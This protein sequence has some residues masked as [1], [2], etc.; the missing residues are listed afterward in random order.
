[1]TNLIRDIESS[2]TQADAFIAALDA[3]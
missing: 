3:E 1:V 2:I